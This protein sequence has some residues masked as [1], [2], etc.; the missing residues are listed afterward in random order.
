MIVRKI[1]D[2]PCVLVSEADMLMLLMKSKRVDELQ[3]E[4]HVSQRILKSWMDAEHHWHQQCNV[5]RQ[6]LTTI[7][8]ALRDA[9]I[10]LEDVLTD[11]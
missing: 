9:G 1:S 7:V 6:S 4:L 8:K 2:A 10:S 5:L 3:D 11:A